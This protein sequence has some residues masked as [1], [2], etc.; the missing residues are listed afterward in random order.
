MLDQ[1]HISTYPEAICNLNQKPIETIKKFRYLGDDIQF[2]Q[3]STGDAEVELRIAV[4]E[5]KF[6]QLY[7][8]LTNRNIKLKW[9]AYNDPEF[10]GKKSFDILMSDLE[11]NTTTTK[12]HSDMLHL[13]AQKNDQ[14]WF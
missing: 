14:T 5:S 8:K 7:K 1:Q 4:A 10:N 3:L 11:S 13:N 9:M 12:A 2:D 6:N